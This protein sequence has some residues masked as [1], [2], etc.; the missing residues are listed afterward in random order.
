MTLIENMER[1]Q[2]HR[3][4]TALRFIAGA[5]AGVGAWLTAPWGF[6]EVS[7]GTVSGW[8]LIVIGV[9]LAVAAVLAIVSGIRRT[10]RPVPG[11]LPPTFGQVPA[12]SNPRPGLGWAGTGMDPRPFDG[13]R[14]PGP[15]GSGGS[16]R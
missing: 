3:R 16:R 9:A 10:P 13:L 5:V 2:R 6:V 7:R 14:D 15:G 4:G 8:L 12:P 1:V 11:H